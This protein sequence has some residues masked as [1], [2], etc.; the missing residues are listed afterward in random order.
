M[1]ISG[2]DYPTPDG[3]C[4]R[5]YVHVDDLARAHLWPCTT[6]PKGSSFVANCGYGHGFSV[7]EVLDTARRVTGVAFP[8]EEARAGPATRRCWS[9][10]A[11]ASRRCSAGRPGDDLAYI[12]GTAWRWEQRL[13]AMRGG[14]ARPPEAGV[15]RSAD[16]P[17]LT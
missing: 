17:E 12:V 7:R 13:Q 10:T 9:P 4:I 3:T 15:S 6:S 14:A 8:I 16:A 2:T 5:D 11:A 1:R